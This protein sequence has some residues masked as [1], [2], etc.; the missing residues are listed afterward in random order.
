MEAIILCGGRPLRLKPEISEPKPLVKINDVSL[1]QYQ[2]NW[3]KGRGFKRIVLAIN[4]EVTVDELPSDAVPSIET[5]PLGT[6]GATR[7]ALEKI[8][9]T[10]VYVMNVDDIVFYDPIDLYDQAYKGASILVSKPRLPFGK[11]TLSS[12]RDV[13]K[14]EEKPLLDV[15]ASCGHYVFK[16]RV[17]EE[18]FPDRGNIEAQ[19]FQILADRN[20]L[21]AFEYTGVWLTINTF[22]DLLD[23]RNLFKSGK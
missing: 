17:I 2:V 3:L 13:L 22:K 12:N 16:K 15:Y 5:E 8:V 20:L 4:K 10:K 7:L 21:R 6:A 23:A 18:Y 11:I 1:V 14:F 19:T 9:D